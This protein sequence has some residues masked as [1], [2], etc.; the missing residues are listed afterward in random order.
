MRKLFTLT[1]GLA[2]GSLLPLAAVHAQS[3]APQVALEKALATRAQWGAADYPAAEVRVSSAYAEP[4]G[5]QHVY[6]QQLYQGIPVYNRMQS[7]TFKDSRLAAHS[8][9]F[10]P[11]KELAPLSAKP[12]IDA[13]RA[14]RLALQHL[15]VAATAPTRLQVE[16]GPEARQTF[17][18]ADVARHDIVV[19]LTWGFDK[20]Q[21]P[22][23]TWNV[24]VD[25][26]ST[27][28]W[29]NI[30]VDAQTGA[31]VDQDNWTSYEASPAA[32]TGTRPAAAPTK[33]YRALD[34]LL[35]LAPPTTTTS[36]YLVLPFPIE[37][38][39]AAGAG[40]QTD[41]DP[42]LRAGATNNAV[43]NGWHFDG[44]TNYVTTRGN[45]VAAY[46]DGAAL[47]V[48]GSYAT[49]LTPAPTLSFAYPANFA[50]AA[51]TT[52]NR[53]AA[54]TNLFYWNNIIH[55]VTYQY[56]FTEVAGNFQADNLG[57]GGLG[58]DFVLAE[59][60]DGMGVGNANFSTPVDGRNG[61]MQ[62]YLWNPTA[63]SYSLTVTAPAAVAGSYAA[64]EG[65]VSANNTLAAVGPVSGQLAL[66][67]DA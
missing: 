19:S 43:T 26:L 21:R 3:L 61:R 46:D 31:V 28:D 51:T 34:A 49:S 32:P 39:S 58:G 67:T 18:K 23:L 29:W 45:N 33:G 63:P 1:M 36:S 40:F 25:L 42:W 55:D 35:A 15:Q 22:H 4:N 62:M 38:P 50:A 54:V 53:N 6:L 47:N 11:A 65:R 20:N 27:P 59:A 37:R 57:R 52:A 13:A 5:L 41:T 16:Q 12:A 17:D 8:G 30:R 64:V 2:A 9:N 66:Y 48:P 56:G 10:L 44:T 7:L 60:Q 24:N 14:V